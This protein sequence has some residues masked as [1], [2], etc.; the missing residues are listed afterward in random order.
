LDQCQDHNNGSFVCQVHGLTC[1]M[2]CL[3]SPQACVSAILRRHL[4]FKGWRRS[5]RILT[6]GPVWAGASKNGSVH[7]DSYSDFSHQSHQS[8]RSHYQSD[9]RLTQSN[10]TGSYPQRHA[11]CE[12]LNSALK[13]AIP[14]CAA[15]KIP[16]ISKSYHKAE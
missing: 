15:H 2:W 13:L 6:L 9:L 10:M 11:W 1:L 12:A 14:R 5:L 3:R 7:E 8:P 16:Y 4:D